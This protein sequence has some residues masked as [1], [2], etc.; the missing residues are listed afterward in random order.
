MS[1]VKN[2]GRLSTI[3]IKKSVYCKNWT[4][5]IDV[6]AVRK[7]DFVHYKRKKTLRDQVKMQIDQIS[8]WI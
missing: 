5:N 3:E 4:R 6:C 2:D 7:V 1:T 8:Q